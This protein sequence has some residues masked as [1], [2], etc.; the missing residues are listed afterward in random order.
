MASATPWTYDCAAVQRM[1]L[2]SCFVIGCLTAGGCVGAP[3]DD[4][5]S[6]DVTLPSERGAY[7]LV[8]HHEEG[9]FR[10]GVND[11]V[12][13]VVDA[14]G[15]PAALT[16]VDAVMPSHAHESGTGHVVADGDA[17]RVEDLALLMP[18]RWQIT[19]R[20]GDETRHDQVL[21]W[22]TLR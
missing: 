14:E 2:V 8:L 19:F 15:R 6:G 9:G 18:G 3:V 1:L 12:A 20:L 5:A 7:T 17:W 13:R 22:V 10:R 21:V 16:A 11:L 4:G